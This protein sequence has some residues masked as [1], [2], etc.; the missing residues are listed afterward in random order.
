MFIK[1]IFKTHS[2]I[3]FYTRDQAAKLLR[4]LRA[5]GVDIWK[6]SFNYGVDAGYTCDF[7]NE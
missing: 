6:D 1:Q 2:H 5:K 4:A 3:A 7:I